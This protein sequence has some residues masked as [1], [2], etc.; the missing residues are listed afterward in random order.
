M[1]LLHDADHLARA[2][3]RIESLNELAFAV[4]RLERWQREARER[5]ENLLAEAQS[6]AAESSYTGPLGPEYWPHNIPTNG[7]GALRDRRR[8]TP[9]PSSLCNDRLATDG[10]RASSQQHPVQHRHAD[11]S[12]GL[13]GSKAASSQPR[14]DQRFVAAHCRFY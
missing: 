1:T 10:I 3:R 11:G 5:L 2:L 4:G 6:A 7:V 12:L 8:D 14:P 9:N 13:L